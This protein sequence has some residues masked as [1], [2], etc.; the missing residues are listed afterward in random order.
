MRS[1]AKFRDKL[2]AVQGIQGHRLWCQSRIRNRLLASQFKF[3]CVA[4]KV[5]RPWPDRPDR[6]RRPWIVAVPRTGT[7]ADC[8]RRSRAAYHYATRKVRR[9]EEHN[10]C[11]WTYSNDRDFFWSEIKRIRCK[12]V[13]ISRS[14]DGISDSD[15]ASISKQT[16]QFADK[17]RKIY[18]YVCVLVNVICRASQQT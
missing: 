16:K 11:V 5:V 17:C 18:K 8:M 13:G 15:S 4:E 14:V 9:N 7:V 12:S 2:I 1:S 10:Y 6:R 3:A